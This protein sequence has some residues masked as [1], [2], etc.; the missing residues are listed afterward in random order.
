LLLEFRNMQ[1]ADIDVFA[2]DVY[3]QIHFCIIN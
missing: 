3:F 2:L 1:N